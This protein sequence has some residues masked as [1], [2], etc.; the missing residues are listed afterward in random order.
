M[1]H[2][3]HIMIWECGLLSIFYSSSHSAEYTYPPTPYRVIRLVD[4]DHRWFGYTTRQAAQVE[5]AE[6]H[7]LLHIQWH[8]PHDHCEWHGG[9]S[10]RFFRM[11]KRRKRRHVIDY[12][13][14]KAGAL[15]LAQ[16]VQQLLTEQNAL[17]FG[18]AADDHLFI[19]NGNQNK[20]K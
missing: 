10:W 16:R 13:D 8:W 2:I 15:L 14:P 7:N 5:H 12:E 17:N 18:K 4:L 11:W 20:C 1:I 9:S 6:A 3:I 19:P